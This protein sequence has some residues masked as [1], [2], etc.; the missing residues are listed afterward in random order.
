MFLSTIKTPSA[1]KIT[2][3]VNYVNLLLKNNNGLFLTD[4]A[5]LNVCY[6]YFAKCGKNLN[7]TF[8]FHL[9]Y[10]SY[11]KMFFELLTTFHIITTKTSHQNN[12]SSYPDQSLC[13]WHSPPPP[14]MAIITASASY[15]Y[16]QSLHGICSKF[17][18]A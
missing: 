15:G 10:F 3:D 8:V 4:N 17:S 9:N 12:T 18:V 11:L 7:K 5:T 14:K 13:H 6:N 1:L 16:G 2:G